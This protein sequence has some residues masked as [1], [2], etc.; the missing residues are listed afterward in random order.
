MSRD[1]W[2]LYA[3]GGGLGHLQRALALA[4]QVAP[5]QPLRLLVN[6]RA[7][8]RVEPQL[9]HLLAPAALANLAI[10][11]RS[12]ALGLAAT[13]AWITA[14]WAKPA[15]ALII[16]TFPRGLLGELAELLPAGP[17]P[18]ILI[19]RDLN[20]DYVQAKNLLP[21][22]A[23]HYEHILIP[24]EGTS[25]PLAALPQIQHTEP[26][27]LYGA[28]ELPSPEAARVR[29]GL[30][31]DPRPLVIVL[32]AGRPEELAGYGQLTATLHQTYPHLAVRCLALELPPGCPPPLWQACY[33][34]LA[35]LPAA[36][37]VVGGGGY[38]TVYECQA[39]GVPLVA[40]PRSRRYDR[41][42]LRVARQGPALCP[43]HSQAE[44]VAAVGAWSPTALPARRPAAGE[45]GAI[46]A[47]AAI[48]ELCRTFA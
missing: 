17:R 8:P 44:A 16:D 37:L 31:D 32:A 7:W 2:L 6:S 12:P 1:P 41:Q 20:P 9:S 28:A 24:G 25:L 13:Q 19:H 22:T 30:G 29:L 23:Q 35:V 15:R 46:A 14:E 38:H 5:W 42:A 4:R 47:A 34:A 39:A 45:T 33:P 27:L 11:W 26:W 10:Q 3:L 21:F 36:S 43:V 48:R 40:W 18:R